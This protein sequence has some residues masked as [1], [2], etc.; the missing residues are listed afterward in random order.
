MTLLSSRISSVLCYN[1]GME[2]NNEMVNHP[3]HYNELSLNGQPI[4]AIDLIFTF[5][6]MQGLT[7]E[8]S[9]LLG[10][11]V[12]YLTRFPYKGKPVQ[13]LEKASWYLNKLITE[14]NSNES[15]G[16]RV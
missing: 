10:N 14:V 1:R 8:Q 16:K 5:A 4:E 12:K 7:G 9:F 13:D 11:V 3:E 6:S 15:N 2:N